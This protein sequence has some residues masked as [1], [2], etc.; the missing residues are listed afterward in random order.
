[1]AR[2]AGTGALLCLLAWCGLQPL[3]GCAAV[4]SLFGARKPQKQPYRTVS[5]PVAYE[6]MRDTP[7]VLII[8]LRQP[9]Q[10]MGSTG[11]LRGALN[12]P[13]PR[14][15]YRLLELRLFRGETFLVY[16]DTDSCGDAGMSVLSASGFD[17]AIL[18]AGG[19][20]HWIHDG[21][22]TFLPSNAPGRFK[23]V[24]EQQLMPE[25]RRPKGELPIV[26]P[27]PSENPPPEAPP[28]L[29]EPNT[30]PGERP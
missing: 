14:L 24:K 6:I 19:I 22:S 8:D 27:N 21:F 9:E 30:Q 23:P 10:Y 1:M 12:I 11:H 17:D 18:I 25:S 2:R 3:A 7:N 26:P 29:P 28:P 20:S 5:P 15:P 13:L 16:C 4:R